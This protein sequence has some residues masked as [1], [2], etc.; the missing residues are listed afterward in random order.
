MEA[1]ECNAMGWQFLTLDFAERRNEVGD[2]LLCILTVGLLVPD[3][4]HAIGSIIV[5]S[6]LTIR[7]CSHFPSE[8]T[9][10]GFH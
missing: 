6:R 9:R 5:R 4:V 3:R 10:R 2:P 7:T 8:E 1:F